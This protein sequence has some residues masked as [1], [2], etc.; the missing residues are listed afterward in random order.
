MYCKLD[1]YDPS[2]Q[3]ESYAIECTKMDGSVHPD[4]L[5]FRDAIIWAGA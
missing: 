1:E 2:E 4:V 5:N 3:Q